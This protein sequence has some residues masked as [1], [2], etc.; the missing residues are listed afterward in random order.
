MKEI[1]IE[2]EG[3]DYFGLDE[4]F[5]L[6]DIE[7]E[8]FLKDLSKANFNKL[9]NSLLKYG[10]RFPFFF[11]RD[12]NN[13]VW[14]LDGT[15]RH[16]VL[17]WMRERPLEY[18]LPDKYPFFKIKAKDIREA[19]QMLLLIS[20]KY[21]EIQDEGLYG[22]IS[23]FK[24]EDD[25]KKYSIGDEA[26][27]NFGEFN[28]NNFQNI[29]LEDSKF[30]PNLAPQQNR[31]KITKDDLDYAMSVLEHKFDNK[32]SKSIVIICPHCLKEFEIDK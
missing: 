22:M 26:I 32:E 10:I 25:W 4:V 16:K 14:I 9:K 30:I 6:Q 5:V 19:V 3:T 7:G 13:K 21:G 2:C 15:Q 20:S 24:L 1:R 11:W 23:K 27:Y 17:S 8:F 18:K 31:K 12:E 28:L 29:W